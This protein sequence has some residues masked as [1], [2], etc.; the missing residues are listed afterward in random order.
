MAGQLINTTSGVS[1]PLKM[2]NAYNFQ[3]QDPNGAN[4]WIEEVDNESPGSD[5]FGT[6]YSRSVLV[7]W[8]ADD[9]MY[10]VV[11]SA[12]GYSYAAKAG[13]TTVLK[14]VNPIWHPRFPNLFA[15]R[16]SDAHGNKF[17]STSNQLT[18]NPSNNGLGIKKYANYN[19]R[20]VTIEFAP[21]RYT[22]L[23]DNVCGN[24]EYNRNVDYATKPNIYDVN[25]QVGNFYFVEGA[26]SP[27]VDI[28]FPGEINFFECKTTFA[29]TWRQ[30]PEDFICD[31]S[32]IFANPSQIT[33]CVGKVNDAAFGGFAAGTL[34]LLEPE[35]DRY[36]SGTLRTE[37][38]RTPVYMYDVFLPIVYFDPKHYGSVRGHNLKPWYNASLSSVST[39]QV[40]YYLVTA[41]KGD[42]TGQRIYGA[43]DFS[44][45]F[46]AYNA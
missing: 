3:L 4:F 42:A 17:A 20:K 40:T 8:V 7:G 24:I 38:G 6:K 34:L 14:R 33:N 11:N 41:K 44:K 37:D 21:L 25:V 32:T 19:R 39:E 26:A 16:V 9:Q 22:I 10:D 23:E 27:P 43:A 45:L 29:A 30:V 46:K 2:P 28:A 5:D 35:I 1:S 13:A 36:V 12:L 18:N 15:A 31:V